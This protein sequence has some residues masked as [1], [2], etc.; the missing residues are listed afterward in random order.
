MIRALLRKSKIVIM[1]EPTE[2]VDSVTQ[3]TIWTLID[4][5]FISKG[6]TLIAIAHRVNSIL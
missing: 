1:D 3:E 5:E 2:E 4:E 6:V